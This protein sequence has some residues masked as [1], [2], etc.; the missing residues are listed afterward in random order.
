MSLAAH[1]NQWHIMSFDVSYHV[2]SLAVQPIKHCT[3]SKRVVSKEMSVSVVNSSTAVQ[4]NIFPQT[5]ILKEKIEHN[6]LKLKS[7]LLF[8]IIKV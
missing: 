2:W 1:K 8:Y 6:Q 7:V 4:K 5:T 3:T